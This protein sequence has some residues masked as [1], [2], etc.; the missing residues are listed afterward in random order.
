MAIEKELITVPLGETETVPPFPEEDIE[1][2]VEDDGSALVD[3]QPEVESPQTNFEDNLA[4]YLDDESL[5]KLA[6]EL[7]GYYEEDKD[8]RSD[9][10]TAFAN[11]LD[12]LGIKQEERTQP[13]E[14][15]S[16]VNHPLL[17]LIHI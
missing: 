13:F 17:S 9:W 14:G 5:G 12:L 4:E 11:G 6:S 10:Y 16:G 8:S 1:I 3:F 2:E 7:T 15:A